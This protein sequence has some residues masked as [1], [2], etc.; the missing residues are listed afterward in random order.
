[1]PRWFASVAM[2]WCGVGGSH[3][4]KKK[5]DCVWLPERAQKRN[6]EHPPGSFG[7]GT[8]GK[9]KLKGKKRREGV[10]CQWEGRTH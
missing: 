1:M 6:Q 4:G 10:G 8:K 3:W 5:K 9:K 2:K 7:G